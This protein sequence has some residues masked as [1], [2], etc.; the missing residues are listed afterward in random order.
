M[1]SG[2]TPTA[3]PQHGVV[4]LD[5]GVEDRRYR[6]WITYI[7]DHRSTPD[8]WYY[9]IGPWY[10]ELRA[11]P[12]ETVG[13]IGKVL[14]RSGI[15][16]HEFDNTQVCHG[17]TCIFSGTC[18]DLADNFAR[19]DVPLDL[20]VAALRAMKN[21]YKDCLEPRCAPFLGHLDEGPKN[22][23][24]TFVYMLWDTNII[25][26]ISRNLFEMNNA[27]IEVMEFALGLNN[28]ACVESALHGL[29]HAHL[30][31]DKLVEMIIDR[32]LE[33][34]IDIN[35]TTMANARTGLRPLRSEL[36]EYARRAR[37]GRII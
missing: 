1:V 14:A 10:P 30:Y 35:A 25:Q 6:E 19:D 27:I 22:P 7:F 23:L 26:H 34:S 31:H 33:T 9:D 36:R 20:K 18:S 4:D 17:L 15:D 37:Q 2:Q 11:R 5:F 28:D 13:L 8:A 29:G 24:N 32:F 3:P 12:T 21:L 16:L